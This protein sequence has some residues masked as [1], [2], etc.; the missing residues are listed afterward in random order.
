VLQT[1]NN[2]RR[3]VSWLPIFLAGAAAAVFTIVLVYQIVF[4][5]ASLYPLLVGEAPG[6]SLDRFATLVSTWGSRA[7]FFSLSTLAA[8][9]TAQR[10]ARSTTSQAMLTGA[11]AA[12]L[13]EALNLFAFEGVHLFEILIYLTAGVVAGYLGGAWARRALADQGAFDRATRMISGAQRPEDVAEAFSVLGNSKVSSVTLW[14][15]GNA[16]HESGLLDRFELWAHWPFWSD[17]GQSTVGLWPT[18]TQLTEG[19]IPRLAQGGTREPV[20]VTPAALSSEERANWVRLGIRSACLVPVLSSA[21][22]LRGLILVAFRTRWRIPGIV[23]RA[24]RNVAA[25]AATALEN[26]LAGIEMGALKERQRVAQDIHD[27]LAQAFSGIVMHLES[28]TNDRAP[29]E[30]RRAVQ[31]ALLAAREGREDARH[32]LLGQ[33]PRQ[34]DGRELPDALERLVTSWSRDSG[35]PASVNTR[36]NPRVLAPDAEIGL[37]R[38]AQ[39]ALA[40]VRKHARAERVNLSLH[41]AGNRVV[42]DIYDN[43]TG[44]EPTLLDY[45]DGPASD[46]RGLDGMRW[47]AESLGG[48]LFLASAAGK[49]TRI[50]AELPT[51]ADAGEPQ[52]SHTVD[53]VREDD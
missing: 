14:R 3:S 33:R 44:F 6:S 22:G 21:G 43:G 31:L 15:T 50:L 19:T 38:I 49:G 39:E 26:M 5:Y 9:F 17:D 24:Y 36:G 27:S 35:V 34:L 40:N 12:L 7:I 13:F 45:H 1:V 52:T 32:L 23:P 28:L 41:F 51:A 2:A 16:R 11:V 30:N 29:E 47:R 53:T 48:S 25:H 10:V 4:A 18:G 20:A 8:F 46:Q 37:Y 42:L